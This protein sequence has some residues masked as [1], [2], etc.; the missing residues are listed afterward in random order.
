MSLGL[1]HIILACHRLVIDPK[2]IPFADNTMSK[3]SLVTLVYPIDMLVM[4]PDDSNDH[5]DA[6]VSIDSKKNTKSVMLNNAPKRF[7]HVAMTNLGMA[8]VVLCIAITTTFIG[9]S[10]FIDTIAFEF[11]GLTGLLLQED[12]NVNYSLVSVA[13][14][15]PT[16]SG[17]PHDFGVRWLQASFYLFGLVMPLSLMLGLLL[18]WFIPLSLARQRELFVL[19]EVLAIYCSDYQVFKTLLFSFQQV[20]NAWA[21]IDVFCIAIAAALLEI[22]QFAMFIVGDACDGINQALA[23][24]VMIDAALDGDDKCFDVDAK[25]KSVLIIT[26]LL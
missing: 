21:T 24:F 6:G 9:I 13:N 10:T 12:A 19:V 8:A 23:S 4:L 18:I 22:S 5:A 15:I 17:K 25:L 26:Y 3:E 16:A 11:K 1:G 2:I 20:L 7:M 14:F